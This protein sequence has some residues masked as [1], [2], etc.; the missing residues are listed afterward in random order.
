MNMELLNNVKN[1]KLRIT[2]GDSVSEEDVRQ[3]FNEDIKNYLLEKYNKKIVFRNEVKT[4]LRQFIDSKWEN[5]VIEYKKT[6]VILGEEQRKQL[7]GYL[8]E[9]GKYAWGILTNGKEMEIY[10]Y[11]FENF[12]HNFQV[13]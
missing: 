3:A 7:K 2:K 13:Y 5:F 12:L 4:S 9:L 10:S 8:N 6:S 1:L 11:S